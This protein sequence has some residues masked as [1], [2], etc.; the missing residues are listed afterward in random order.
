VARPSYAWACGFLTDPV[1]FFT[2]S[3]ALAVTKRKLRYAI[4]RWG[5]FAFDQIKFAAFASWVCFASIRG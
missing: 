4:A 2:N 3:T 5:L 1:Q